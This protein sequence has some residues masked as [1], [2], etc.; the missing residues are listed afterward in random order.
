LRGTGVADARAS[1]GGV[2]LTRLESAA[3]VLVATGHDA[4]ARGSLR[5]PVVRGWVGEGAVAWVGVDA[6]EHAPYLSALGTPAAVAALLAELLTQLP[7]QQR[8]T[9]PR[10]TAAHLPAWVGLHG[11]DWDFRWLPAPPARQPGEELVDVETDESAVQALLTAA[12]PKASAQ[13]GDGAVRRWLGLRED[14]VLL[15]CAADTSAATGVGHLSSIAVD[16]AARG[17]GLGRAITAALSRR[18][19]D[20]GCDI[21]TLG[22]YADNAAGRAMYDKLG[23]RDEHRFTSGPL[24][25]R[26]RW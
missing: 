9:L 12:S 19:F 25:V 15:A 5:R 6:E 11:T 22:M 17:R 24:Q 3:E 20:D 7:P 4:F 26:G 21:V 8:V 2:A 23:Y 1:L 14:A 13:P 18:L 16:P 10:G